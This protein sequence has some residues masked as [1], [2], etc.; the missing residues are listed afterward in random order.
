MSKE[1]DEI[2]SSWEVLENH[3]FPPEAVGW[4]HRAIAGLLPEAIDCAL[5]CLIR[6]REDLLRE[7]IELRAFRDGNQKTECNLPFE[8]LPQ[9]ACDSGAGEPPTKQA[10]LECQLRGGP[11]SATYYEKNPDA[12]KVSSP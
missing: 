8:R 1:R 7:V 9:C 5:D 2:A 6:Q 12:A 4:P 11:C 10:M 3:S